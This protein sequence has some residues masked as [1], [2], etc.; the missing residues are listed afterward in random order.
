MGVARD[1]APTPVPKK[2]R[3]RQPL[4]SIAVIERAFGVGIHEALRDVVPMRTIVALDGKPGTEPTEYGRF[5]AAM[6]SVA[7]KVAAKAD[8]RDPRK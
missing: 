6:I 7:E 5:E 8:R 2:S 4:E 3:W 1:P